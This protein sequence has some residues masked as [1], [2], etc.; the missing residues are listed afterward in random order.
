MTLAACRV[1]L[2]RDIEL[3][4]VLRRLPVYIW[5]LPEGQVH[6]LAD[7]ELNL[8]R[9]CG[10]LQLQDFPKE[11]FPK[12][13]AHEPFNLEDAAE[14]LQRR[15]RLESALGAGFFK[16][17]RVLDV[18]GG[19]NSFA[20]LLPSSKSWVADFSVAPEV[21]A[22]VAR[23]IEGD[24]L[25]AAL[26]PAYFDAICL[27]HCLEHINHP[28]E[29][30]GTLKDLLS[31]GGQV[32]V[33]LPNAPEVIA[34]MPYYAVFHQHV[35]LFSLES[36]DRLMARGG[37]T[38]SGLLRADGVILASYG[39]GA[40]VP[41]SLPPSEGKRHAE[42]LRRRLHAFEQGLRGL[43][44][45]PDPKK[46][47]LY[48]AGGSASLFLA[49]FPWLAQRIG[50]CFDRDARKHGRYLPG[51]ALRIRP[52]EEIES[53]GVSQLLFLSSALHAAVSRGK[54][55]ACLDLESLVRKVPT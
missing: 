2:S 18:G 25:E 55:A 3:Q 13:Y 45:D 23:A 30:V 10:H 32:L 15:D 49:H 11:F 24:I 1:C 37:L 35:S 39:V 44:L 40:V 38:R 51:G 7:A 46:V 54:R 36:L 29:L 12:L 41:D 8:C 31:P 19:R 9:H 52:P 5:P 27:F 28:A 17:K 26:P 6:E 16:G 21:K 50:F 43:R 42:L 14:N 34:R 48:G 33:E 20:A 53:S 4:A 47:G 22:A